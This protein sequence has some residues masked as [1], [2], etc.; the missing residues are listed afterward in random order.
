MACT[1]NLS[2]LCFLSGSGSMLRGSWS[3]DASCL[4]LEE[5]L[6]ALEARP[7]FGQLSLAS[8]K[9]C[10]HLASGNDSF[11]A[12]SSVF[13]LGSRGTCLSSGLGCVTAAGI[14]CLASTSNLSLTTVT[15]QS[16]ISLTI[17]NSG[18]PSGGE[19]T[20]IGLSRLPTLC[21]LWWK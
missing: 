10:L 12:S 6:G 4:A 20:E 18:L 21:F 11:W 2:S 7:R 9:E 16:R 13:S 5:G 15:R 17:V 3:L 19:S 8:P 1:Q 14:I